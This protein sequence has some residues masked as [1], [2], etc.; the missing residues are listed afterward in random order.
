L[1]VQFHTC[2]T[3]AKRDLKVACLMFHGGFQSLL[4]MINCNFIVIW[5]KFASGLQV[6]NYRLVT[7][8]HVGASCRDYTISG[9][10]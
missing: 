8:N 3:N 9:T 7:F 1:M 5:T 2:A 6:L 10:F 4:S